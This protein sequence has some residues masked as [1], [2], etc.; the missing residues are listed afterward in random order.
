MLRETR[1][2][3]TT[4]AINDIHNSGRETSS[5]KEIGQI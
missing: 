3:F 4:F 2:G 5:N 1:A